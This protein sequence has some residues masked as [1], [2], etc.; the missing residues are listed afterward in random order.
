MEENKIIWKDK[1][2]PIFGLPLSFTNYTLN[3]EKLIC[4]YGILSR[5]QEEIWLYRILDVTVTRTLFQR[6]FNVGTIHICSNDK[7]TPEFN[8]VSVKDPLQIKE[9]ISKK[10][11]EE[12]NSKNVRTNEFLNGDE[13]NEELN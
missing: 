1:K 8:I 7:S 9:V 6:I 10:V 4:D 5:T 12:R 2:R 13:H 3:E 11:N